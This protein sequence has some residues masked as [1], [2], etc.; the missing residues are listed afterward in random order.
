MHIQNV[1]IASLYKFYFMQRLLLTAFVTFCFVS[2]AISQKAQ[3][4]KYTL[5]GKIDG[6]QNTFI[7]LKP[8]YGP[9]YG[10]TDSVF[11]TDGEFSFTGNVKEP[12]MKSIF[13]RGEKLGIGFILEAGKIKITGVI[14]DMNNASVTGG[15]ENA[16][17]NEY[18]Q[19]SKNRR[20][21]FSE[22]M[23]ALK[24]YK[25]SG[26]TVNYNEYNK[27]WSEWGVK[28]NDE[29]V[30]FIKSHPAS[31]ASLNICRGKLG[32][33]E[34]VNELLS[35]LHKSLQNHFIY[36]EIKYR[37]E[38]EL[39]IGLN[40]LAPDFK[41]PLPNGSSYSL[42][43]LKGKFILLD[44]W[45]SWCVPCRKESPA[46]VNA[47]KTFSSKGFEIV[48]V[49]LDTEKEKWLEAIEKDSYT[50]KNLCDL[51]G[52]NNVA[53]TLYGVALVPKNFL[54]DDKGNII[55]MDIKGEDLIAK[56]NEVIK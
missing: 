51:K 26:D 18:R 12:V 17:Y 13:V 47:Y 25:A 36:K 48:S 54:I 32:S 50:W 14:N 39:R 4:G 46:L 30:E 33:P 31:Y 3:S 41:Q 16:A 9:T 24:Q 19:L 44:F 1:R 34:L 15:K 42:S 22:I 56:L 10:E 2:Q 53:A 21:E 29:D 55:A 38:V 28:M 23:K 11:T 6:A 37:A 35:Y 8:G 43:S 40:K 5:T 45:A 20:T 7:Y 49:S 27:K 52:Y